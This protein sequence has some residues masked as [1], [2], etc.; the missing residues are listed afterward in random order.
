MLIGERLRAAIEDLRIAHS[1]SSIADH[2]TLSIGG[3]VALR[4]EITP[5]RLIAAADAALYR[6]KRAGRN[7]AFVGKLDE[8]APASAPIAARA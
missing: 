2:V 8:A 3:V 4:G 6:A 1:A 5:E 7:R